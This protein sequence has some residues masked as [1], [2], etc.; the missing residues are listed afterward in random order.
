MTSVVNRRRQGFSL[1]ELVVVIALATV[2]SMALYRTLVFQQR[3][4]R[5]QGAVNSTQD[6]LRL[7]WSV[8]AADLLEANPGAGDFGFVAAESVQVRSPV[9]FAMICDTNR[10]ER[11]LGL[12]NVQG[13]VTNAPGDSLLIYD[14]AGWLVR[15]IEADNTTGGGSLSCPYAA[16]PSMAKRIRVDGPVDSVRVGTPIRA[17]HRYTYKL[18]RDGDSWWLARADASGT[19]ILAGPF[20]GGGSGLVFTYFDSVGQTTTNAADVARVDLT[21]VAVSKLASA[22]R[23][24]LGISASPRN[25]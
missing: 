22:K 12:F 9:G 4:Y 17:F 25:Q 24:S 18:E 15:R 14:K 1:A 11:V 7:A 23:D 6:A 2:V 16:G 10:S 5:Q 20:S 8:V 13:R 21:L 19:D 3:F